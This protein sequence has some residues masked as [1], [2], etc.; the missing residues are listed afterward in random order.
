LLLRIG[1]VIVSSFSEGIL[2]ND[3]SPD[4]NFSVP[5]NTDGSLLARLD[6]ECCLSLDRE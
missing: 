6:L 5:K 2:G 4:R 3:A 1:F